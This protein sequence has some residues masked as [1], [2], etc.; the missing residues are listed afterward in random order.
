M[1]AR[2]RAEAIGR[3]VGA[4]EDRAQAGHEEWA[5][6]ATQHAQVEATR[7]AD[8]AALAAL[9]RRDRPLVAPE[10]DLP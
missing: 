5:A 9:L 6:N 8:L 3:L 1:I 7:L 2:E 10:G 4:I